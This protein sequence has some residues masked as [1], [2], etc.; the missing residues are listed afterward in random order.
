MRRS[1]KCLFALLLLLNMGMSAAQAEKRSPKRALL[2]A[3]S[4][5]VQPY[6]LE[7]PAN[8]AARMRTWLTATGCSVVTRRD[9]KASELLEAVRAAAVGIDADGMLLLYFA[10]HCDGQALYGIDGGYV[11]GPELKEALDAL[12]CEKLIIVDACGSGALRDVFS[13]EGYAL[14]LSSEGDDPSV[15]REICGTKHGL[16]TWFLTMGCGA[17]DPEAKVLPADFNADGKVSLREACRFAH[18][19]ATGANPDQSC[20]VWPDACDDIFLVDRNIAQ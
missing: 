3:E 1:I 16:F 15:E 20:I 19:K 4:A 6:T 13:E 18:I 12:P 8:D 7:G 5:Y 2:I 9:L 11:T 14:A 17:D 10:G